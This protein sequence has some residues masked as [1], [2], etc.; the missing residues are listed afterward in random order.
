MSLSSSSGDYDSDDREE[1]IEAVKRDALLRRRG[2]YRPHGAI[3]RATWAETQS[4][5][6]TASDRLRAHRERRR[7]NNREERRRRLWNGLDASF[8][9]CRPSKTTSPAIWTD[10][11]QLDRGEAPMSSVDPRHSGP[12]AGAAQDRADSDWE[13]LDGWDAV[14][15]DAP[16]EHD[17][18]ILCVDENGEP[19]YWI[20]ERD[21]VFR[22]PPT[23][24]LTVT[25]A[26]AQA[27]RNGLSPSPEFIRIESKY[28]NLLEI[29][30]R[31]RSRKAEPGGGE[32]D[33]EPGM[34]ATPAVFK[35]GKEVR[36]LN[37]ASTSRST[38]A[39]ANE[40]L[41]RISSNTDGVG[42]LVSISAEIGGGTQ[43]DG[44]SSAGAIARSGA[45]ARHSGNIPR[46]TTDTGSH[47]HALKEVARDGVAPD[48]RA[49]RHPSPIRIGEPSQ[50]F[51]SGRR[52]VE[53]PG[54]L[55]RAA[56]KY[57]TIGD[58]PRR[59]EGDRTVRVASRMP[60]P[61]ASKSPDS[62]RTAGLAQLESRRASPRSPA[63]PGLQAVDCGDTAVAMVDR[64]YMQDVAAPRQLT[65]REWLAAQSDS[66]Q[67]HA[68]QRSR[69]VSG[70]DAPGRFMGERVPAGGFVSH[71][72]PPSVAAA[73]KESRPAERKAEG[74]LA[75]AAANPPRAQHDRS[76]SRLDRSAAQPP[77]TQPVVLHGRPEGD[78]S[79][80]GSHA[81]SRQPG[82]THA[83]SK[84]STVSIDAD[85]LGRRL[86][87]HASTAAVRPRLPKGPKASTLPEADSPALATLKVQTVE[88]AN[89][90]TRLVSHE[91]LQRM[92]Q[93]EAVRGSASD[94][95]S[96][97]SL[98]GVVSP[99][100]AAHMTESARSRGRRVSHRA[101][102]SSGSADGQ[103]T[104]VLLGVTGS[105]PAL[106]PADRSV[107]SAA[108]ASTATGV[109][110][111]DAP[112]ARSA[113]E[114]TRAN[115]APEPEQPRV[116]PKMLPSA[117]SLVLAPSAS[118]SVLQVGAES[119]V[120]PAAL[121]GVL[122]P[123][124][125]PRGRGRGQAVPR[126]PGRDDSAA[127]RSSAPWMSMLGDSL[128][129][130]A[131][132]TS[133]TDGDVPIPVPTSPPQ[134]STKRLGGRAARSGTVVKRAPPSQVCQPLRSADPT[135]S[136]F[137]S[138]PHRQQ[139][140]SSATASSR[141]SDH[142][143]R[144]GG[145]SSPALDGSSLSKA[146]AAARRQS[147]SATQRIRGA[148]SVVSGSLW[149]AS[150]RAARV[151]AS[152]SPA[153]P[154]SFSASRLDGGSGVRSGQPPLAKQQR[155]R[156]AKSYSEIDAPV[157]PCS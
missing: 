138:R 94:I 29:E 59:L 34:P 111:Q 114:H 73:H 27:E 3:G 11:L 38:D 74:G 72:T 24:E 112:A 108:S 146:R 81:S 83:Q 37:S 98:K 144:P 49:C 87:R 25:E 69:R 148:T 136:M 130:R 102:A 129:P 43:A 110:L 57:S 97:T 56:G 90:P 84:L 40:G 106:P 22:P 23:P 5:A 93:E 153:M 52:G 141:N 147:G 7:A 134:V 70:A 1:R 50:P 152:R 96:P 21:G 91:E 145:A 127:H 2:E 149:G 88:I 116:L 125:Q 117:T 41:D 75:V 85:G 54:S 16:W 17:P 115:E 31:T 20:F 142:S 86:I 135:R 60:A 143:D 89:A 4:K 53:S 77:A 82:A 157:V 6:L 101:S 26:V 123:W 128:P 65:V 151:S 66:K 154:A 124:R 137:A 44:G 61:R 105:R 79:Y 12:G 155:E 47:H 58:L 28:A 48:V 13:Q 126:Q 139:R 150:S 122:S 55:P 42:P 36:E 120:I 100:A 67:R 51:R 80:G 107:S 132:D 103:V 131:T 113:S 33:G 118:V 104:R 14:V 109:Q 92:R 78:G 30:R 71:A 68:A 10:G 8:S 35:A 32:E 76:E 121:A 9:P 64:A 46:T 63:S 95:L 15:P 45:A 156:A 119:E 133:V 18:G 99:P 62:L 39:H 19:S 140:L